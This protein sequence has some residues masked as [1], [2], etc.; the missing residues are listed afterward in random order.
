MI[1]KQSNWLHF[2]TF[3]PQIH[4]DKTDIPNYS[5]VIEFRETDSGPGSQVVSFYSLFLTRLF[6]GFFIAYI[7]IRT[8]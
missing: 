1:N 3:L 7:F 4:T 8:I 5:I 2:V 6:A